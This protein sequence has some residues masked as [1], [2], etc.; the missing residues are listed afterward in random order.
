MNALGP[1]HPMGPPQA[2]LPGLGRDLET[3]TRRRMNALISA[4]LKDTTWFNY[5]DVLEW[6]YEEMKALVATEMVPDQPSLLGGAAS[7][8]LDQSTDG[9]SNMGT[10]SRFPLEIIHEMMNHMDMLTLS[11]FG[12]TCRY[13]LEAFKSQPTYK[14]LM[15]NS[16]NKLPELLS[17]TKVIY[18]HSLLNL[19][20]E[21]QFPTCRACGTLTSYLYLP[22]CER[23]CRNCGEFDKNYWV[24]ETY[25]AETAFNL[26]MEDLRS[27]VPIT[28]LKPSAYHGP[29]F[30]VARRGT[31]YLCPVKS[32]MEVAVRHWGSVEL[33]REAAEQIS[34]DRFSDCTER[35]LTDA[36]LFRY[37]R[38]DQPPLDPN[39]SQD[40]LKGRLRATDLNAQLAPG[41]PHVPAPRATDSTERFYCKGCK[42]CIDKGLAPLP[43]AL[44][45]MGIDPQS[46][47][48]QVALILATRARTARSCSDLFVHVIS[49]L[50]CCVIMWNA[51][52]TDAD[53]QRVQAAARA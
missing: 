50:G 21:L 6:D 27:G 33:M 24:I 44:E 39:V 14:L 51:R 11:R 7:S 22:T 12:R 28:C 5:V 9:T 41:F 48:S 45:Y 17:S 53:R 43:D 49:C 34:P 35:E 46:D 30:P 47:K 8:N 23:L 42:W 15:E 26:D 18:W 10:L 3:A 36:A 16:N 37:L 38:S 52:A 13:A 29:H 20:A 1:P 40:L 31:S 4:L 19:K 2:Q 25:D 32:V